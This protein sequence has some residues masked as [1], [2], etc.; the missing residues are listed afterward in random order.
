MSNKVKQDS[1]HSSP[2][3]DRASPYKN[4]PA[5]G[6]FHCTRKTKKPCKD[7]SSDSPIETTERQFIRGYN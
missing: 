6:N 5:S 2:S 4:I 1:E 3:L 7:N